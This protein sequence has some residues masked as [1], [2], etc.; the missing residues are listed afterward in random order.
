[1]RIID[2]H[3]HVFPF[4]GERAGFA[5]VEEHLATLQ[6]AVRQHVQPTLR[7]RDNVRVSEP[8]L[9]RL[10]CEGRSSLTDVGFRVGKYGRVEWEA[11]GEGLYLQYMPPL[12]SDM[13]APPELLLAMMDHAGVRTAVLHNDSIYGK[14]NDLFASCASR[15]PDR[16]IA[17]ANVD[18]APNNRDAQ[19]ATLD[20]ALDEQGHRGLF[21]K[22][23]DFFMHDF[24]EDPFGPEYRP[25]WDHVASRQI[26]VYWQVIGVPVPSLENTVRV[27]QGFVGWLAAYAEVP[28]VLVG[29]L[30]WEFAGREKLPDFVRR[31]LHEHPILIEIVYPIQ[32]GG[33]FR[34]PFAECREAA[35]FLYE[36]YG[37]ERIVWGSDAPNVERYCSY[38]QSHE[39]LDTYE[40]LTDEDRRLI[41]GGNLARLFGLD[42][43][44]AG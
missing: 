34:Y 28:V 37:P 5:S 44:E 31:A 21:F 20:R 40:F 42:A 29:G 36:E 16:F 6:W 13:T 12:L 17:L 39:Y 41:L 18:V 15:W 4:L 23:D 11:N 43:S 9:I 32:K 7:K 35:R 22:M 26:P 10:P 14:L 33:S 30:P 3:A 19:C 2:S 27:W 25:F 38:R 24:A 8:T 1:M